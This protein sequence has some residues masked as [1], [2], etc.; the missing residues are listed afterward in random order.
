MEN[1]DNGYIV[2]TGKKDKWIR[3]FRS[4][5]LPP[6]IPFSPTAEEIEQAAVALF[7]DIQTTNEQTFRRRK[8]YH[9]K[10]SL[11]WNEACKNTVCNLQNSGNTNISR[12][13]TQAKLRRAVCTAKRKWADKYIESAD[14][15]EVANWRHR[16]KVTKVP[17]LQGP[18]GLVHVH[19]E[20]A[21]ILS[22]RF[23]AW[24]PPP[25]EPHFYNDPPPLLARLLLPIDKALIKPLLKKA[26]AKSAPGQSGHTWMVLKW[27]WEADAD[28]ITEILT[29]SVAVAQADVFQKVVITN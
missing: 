19:E 13:A 14:L 4:R 25:V 7:E 26:A 11:W 10:A 27:A 3:T 20:V 8:P 18:N 6:L 1:N 2:D 21:D 24:T 23:F 17:S 22:Q 28:C 16:C 29:G 12:S 15:W 5:P 9:P